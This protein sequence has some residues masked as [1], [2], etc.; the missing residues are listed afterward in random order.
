[1]AAVSCVFRSLLLVIAGLT[2]KEL[3]QQIQYLKAE[4]EILRAKLPKRIVIES[5]ERRKLLKYAAKLS[6]SVFKHLTSIV[7]SDTFLRWLRE[8]KR[9]KNK[10][11]PPNKRGRKR[12]PEQIRKLIIK[13]AQENNWG[14]TMILGELKKLG[15]RKI[16]RNTA[17]NILRENGLEPG[18]VDGEGT[19]DEFL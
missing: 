11:K 18:P 10:P 19:W 6:R 9:A 13:L 5:K 1:M 14:Y 2:K 8:D 12:S 15:V 4:N 17:K 7:T 3:V 16:S